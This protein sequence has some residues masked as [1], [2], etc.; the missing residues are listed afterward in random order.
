MMGKMLN[1][2][3]YEE[4]KGCDKECTI[5][6]MVLDFL[7][8]EARNGWLDTSLNRFVA[9]F[10]QFIFK[11]DLFAHHHLYCKEANV[12]I[13]TGHTKKTGCPQPKNLSYFSTM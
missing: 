13:E 9:T 12:T 5:L 10:S 2:L 3:L 4:S 8:L 11:I 1:A 7:T 6:Q